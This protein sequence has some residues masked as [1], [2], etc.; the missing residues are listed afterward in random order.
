MAFSDHLLDGA[1]SIRERIFLHPFVQ[2]IGDG[3]LPR[4]SFGFYMCQ[5]YAY[6]IEY[7]RV[8]ALAVARAPDLPTMGRFAELLHAT[9]GMEMALHRAY[10]A[11]FGISEDD[12]EGT[13]PAATTHAYTRHLLNVAWSGSLGELAASLL[14]CQWDY[15][16][17]GSRL[18]AEGR[19]TEANQ[20]RKWIET[21]AS[22]EFGELAVWIRKLVDTLAE[23]AGRGELA[24]MEREF[25]ASSRYELMFWEMA[26]HGER[27]PL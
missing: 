21:Y 25:V 4:E 20:Y 17:L 9:L 6:L 22:P 16:E 2:G 15:W 19:A 1:K 24:R 27:W 23:D 18:A 3:T 10:A 26:W 11:E 14:P 8:F 5:D 7:C 13:V 12:L